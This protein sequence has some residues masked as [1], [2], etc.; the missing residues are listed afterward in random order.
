MKKIISIFL[1]LLMSLSFAA[2]QYTDNSIG[3]GWWDDFS[4]ESSSSS[5]GDSSSSSSSSVSAEDEVEYTVKVTQGGAP[6]AK[7]EGVTVQWTNGYE[8]FQS[9]IEEGV[10]K[11]S[12]VADDYSVTLLDLDDK[13]SYNPGELIKKATAYS[14]EVEIPI[15]QV[16]KARGTGS[17]GS[18]EYNCKTCRTLGVYR[19]EITE[20]GQRVFY[21]YEPT[22]NGTYTIE[23]WVDVSKGLV[24]P[25]F[26]VY[27]GSS[28]FKTEAY[29][30]DEGGVSQGFTRNFKYTFNVDDSNIGGVWTF[31]VGGDHREGVS[32]DYAGDPVMV[33][34]ALMRGSE[35]HAD[36]YKAPW[37]YADGLYSFVAEE[38]VSLRSLPEDECIEKFVSYM[39]GK[40]HGEMEIRQQFEPEYT[41]LMACTMADFADATS[42]HAAL[43]KI[44]YS[45]TMVET[46]NGEL[47]EKK[48]EDC[49]IRQY[50]VYK[51]KDRFAAL[52]GSGALRGAETDYYPEGSSTSVLA[53]RGENYQVS[54]ITGVYHRYSMD[55]YGNDPYDY[56]AGYGP[57]LFGYITAATRFI[58]AALSAIE[59]AG[60]KA[61]TVENGTENYKLFVEGYANIKAQAD[62]PIDSSGQLTGMPQGFPDA[63]IGMFGYGDF[64]NGNGIVP[65][66]PELKEFFQ[67]FSVAQRLFNDGNGYA[68]SYANPKVD[69]LE[70]D[71]W[72]FACC[73]YSNP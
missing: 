50:V 24:N 4:S 20:H 68:E 52:E 21:E 23:S 32:H 55:L 6:F 72:L 48:D 13:Y 9:E 25:K 33:D 64:V 42:I 7:A 14:P 62:T 8:F 60:N 49:W 34:F 63:A 40:G 65:V 51:I 44:R 53:F 41:A 11:T 31:A 22:E 70:E 57:V 59:Y 56:G 36:R 54:P 29:V 47:V 35:F 43:E 10:A 73:Y 46:V 19:T 45:D 66:T 3:D 15:Y 58:P 1:G 39:K 5:S 26:Y 2:C 71:Q 12:L 28:A 16:T 17:A 30:L 67:K 18:N 37:I 61:L 27:Y 69:A 38:M